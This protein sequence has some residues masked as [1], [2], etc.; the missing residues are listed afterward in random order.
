[1]KKG[2]KNGV[3]HA[4]AKLQINGRLFVGKNMEAID[5]IKRMNKD[6]EV[7]DELQSV[8]KKH[9]IALIDAITLLE[10]LKF[11]LLMHSYGK[12]KKQ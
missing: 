5:K 6:N 10:M 8:F 3:Y 1:V 12:G 11:E 4:S 2:C 9:E 7:M